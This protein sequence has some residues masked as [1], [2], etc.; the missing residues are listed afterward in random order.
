[1]ETCEC[2]APKDPDHPFCVECEA[3]LERDSAC[4]AYD[5]S[6]RFQKY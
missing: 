4:D 2:G 6:W 1:M 5:E 3:D